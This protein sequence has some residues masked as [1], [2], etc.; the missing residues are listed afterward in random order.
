VSVLQSIDVALFRFINGTL[1]NRLFDFLM[2]ILAGGWWFLPIVIAAGATLIWKGGVRGRLCVLMVAIIL[3]FADGW[4]S[5]TIKHTVDRPR[6]CLILENVNL[7]M[8][9]EKPAADDDNDFHRGC[10]DSGS[11]PSAHATNWFA[12][13][14]IAW[15]FY[16]RTWLLTVPMACL[17]A[18]SRVYNGVHFPSD[19]LGGAIVGAGC[20]AAFVVGIDVLWRWVARRWFP[21]WWNALPSLLLVTPSRP[22]VVFES[23]LLESERARH[24]LRLGYFL[25]FVTFAGRLGYIASGRI[26]L[27][28]DEAYQWLWSKHLALSYFSKPPLIAYVQWLGTHVFGDN[29]FGVRFFSPVCAALGS[30]VALRFFAKHLGARAGFWL[31]AIVCVTPLLAVGA[32]LMTVDPLLVL[33]WTLAMFA[34][35][36]AVQSDGRTRDWAVVGLWMGLAFLSKYTALL[37]WLCW[38]TF[39]ALWKPA[40]VHLRRRGMYVALAI[41][42]LC[43]LPVLFWNMQHEWIT[44]AHVAN[45]AKVGHGWRLGW[46]SPL[47]FLGGSMG[48]MHPVFFIA[49]VWAAIAMW[50]NSAAD[51]LLRFFFA[52]G[53][54]LFLVYAVYALHSSILLNWIAASVIPLFCMMVVFWDRRFN[55]GARHVRAFL[56]IAMLLGAFAVGVLHETD[57]T[58]KIAG[59]RLSPKMDPLRRVRGWTQMARVVA[60]ERNKLAA[61]GKPVFVI[62]GHYGTTSLLSFYMPEAR[63]AVKNGSP[64]VYYRFMARPQN[65]FYFWPSYVGHRRGQNAIYVQEKDKP[66]PAP[67]DIVKQFASVT[68]VG[69][70]PIIYHTRV[71]HH[72]QVFACRDLQR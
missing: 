72:V 68:Q 37:Q 61:E 16:R 40:R 47:E 38:G 36:R 69:N 50:K 57:L 65:Q 7:P 51:A 12:A 30:V 62:G 35:W 49:T 26:E 19:V 44:I 55:A 14:M 20:G 18:F 29:A 58:K 63:A 21:L 41:N 24:W 60:R 15:I 42:L 39:F 59:V 67:P 8:R 11:M 45:D 28:E 4:I 52:M 46:R 66:A 10:S 33:F 31:I 23:S 34:G 3:P 54:P 43:A 27:S 13:A 48:L 2:P 6:P 32:T 25:I 22:A 56:S 17:V 53:A 5:N 1:Q 9:L 70:F 64:L 71:L